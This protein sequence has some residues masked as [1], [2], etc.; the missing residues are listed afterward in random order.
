MKNHFWATFIV[1]LAVVI[2][3]HGFNFKGSVP[4][5]LENTGNQVL[6]DIKPS[7]NLDD[8][9]KR[10]EDFG[11]EGR[12]LYKYR[13]LTVDVILPLSVFWFL[14]IF[15]S[16][17]IEKITLRRQLR[18]TLLALPFGFLIF[19]F[20]ENIALYVMISHYPER[21]PLLA[22]ILPY[23]TVVKRASSLVAIFLPLVLIIYFR[24]I[25]RGRGE[26]I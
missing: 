19:D 4:H 11:V 25:Q 22:T 14:I 6:L 10:L 26:L 20:A 17:A 9:Y 1:A 7:F 2:V 15:M 3:V 12:D 24:F 16:K 13:I 21:M 18:W 8:T 23:F 5:F